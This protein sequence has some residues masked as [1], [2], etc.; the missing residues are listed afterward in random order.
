MQLLSVHV[1]APPPEVAEL[2]VNVQ[3][4]SVQGKP[5]TSPYAPPPTV[6]ELLTTV[7]LFS[8]LVYAPPPA[9]AAPLQ[10]R[11]QLYSAQ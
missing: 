8:V 11:V 2:P 9:L 5:P 6:A 10:V 7:Q 1:S 4:F 3:L